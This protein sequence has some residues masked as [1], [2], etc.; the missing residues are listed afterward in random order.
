MKLRTEELENFKAKNGEKETQ[1]KLELEA[2]KKELEEFDEVSQKG[3][4]ILNRFKL[5]ARIEVKK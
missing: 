3:F 2:L 5:E 1:Q 4:D